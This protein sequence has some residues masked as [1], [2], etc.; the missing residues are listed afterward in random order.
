M[1]RRWPSTR[2][3]A[4]LGS[5]GR[6]A[7]YHSLILTVVLGAVVLGLIRNFTSSYQTVA[8]S[9]IGAELR[10]F[11]QQAL[12]RQPTDLQRFAVNFLR[13][14]TLAPGDVVV[15]NLNGVGR[16]ATPRSQ[17]VL[18]NSIVQPWLSS[19]PTQSVAVSTVIDGHPTELVGAPIIAGS[20]AVGTFIATADMSAF[21]KERSREIALSIAEGVIALLVA[22][23]GTFLL[24]RRLLRT[25]GRITTTADEIGSGTLDQRL[26]D[27]GSNDEVGELARTFDSMLD[28]IQVAMD[29]QR[30]LLSDVSHQL[31]TPLTV[32]RGHLEILGRGRADDPIEVHET[33]QIVIDELDHTRAVVERLLSLG[34]AMEPDFLDTR[35]VE[36][37]VLL[38]EVHDAVG[39]LAD[40]QFLLPESPDLVILVD[41]DKLRG[42]LLNLI[43]N[44]VRATAPGDAIALVAEVDPRD[45]LLLLSVEDSGPGI[46]EDQRAAVLQRFSRPG[47]RNQDGSGLGLAIVKAVAEGHGGWITIG[48]SDLDGARV[49]IVLPGARIWASE[50]I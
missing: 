22:I 13:N 4:R 2:L 28:R 43:D 29:S 50:E 36:L 39:V 33:V 16:V 23:A 8:A 6:L 12:Q 7:I 10:D 47:S 32:A 37:R 25:V 17:P 40:R 48:T 45:D 11:Q 21:A 9:S 49:T 20:Q 24:L 27:Q 31:R 26:G 5:A 30:R 3:T 44:A 18:A 42:A 46:P 14:H 38:R 35:P 19:P 34:R 1:R 41:V 15:I